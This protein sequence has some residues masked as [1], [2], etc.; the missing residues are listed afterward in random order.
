MYDSGTYSIADF[1]RDSDQWDEVKKSLFIES[2][3]NNLTIPS[4]FLAATSEG[5][6]EIIDGQQRLT[7]LKEFHSNLLKLVEFDEADY[8]GQRSVHYAGKTFQELKSSSPAYARAFEEYLLSL[9]KLPEGVSDSTRREIFR[10]INEAGTPLSAQDIRLTY[11]G[12][13]KSVALIRLAGIYDE[14]REG[15]VRMVR[16]AN[17]NYGITWPWAAKSQ[18]IKDEWKVWWSGKQTAI[19]QT[20][21]EMF[22]WYLIALSRNQLDG[23]LTN[24][25]HLASVLNTTFDGRTEEAADLF[26]A[27]LKHESEGSGPP[28]LLATAENIEVNLFPAFADWWYEIHSRMPNIGVDRNRRM[29][30]LIAAFSSY[31]LGKLTKSQWDVVERFLRAPRQAAAAL[32]WNQIPEARGR[33]GGARG[34]KAQIDAYYEVAKKIVAM[35]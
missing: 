23:V 22:L 21:S 17:T 7:T 18:A 31:E 25:H 19:G 30:L 2:V 11:Y 35:P 12:R 3:L 13:C 20:A 10:R 4:L 32:G 8:L 9:I 14:T 28:I 5:K 27:Q 15:S 29:A 34:Q 26:C 33:W 1:Q 16:S 24:S 6:Y